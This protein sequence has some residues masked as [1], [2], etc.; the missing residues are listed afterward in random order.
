[1]IKKAQPAITECV[2]FTLKAEGAEAGD[3]SAQLQL[4]LC[5]LKGDGVSNN[6]YIVS[7]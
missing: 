1:M 6:I 7:Y 5:C 2:K 3:A 4:G